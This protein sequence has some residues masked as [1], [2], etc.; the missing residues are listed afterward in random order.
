[1]PAWVV[2][3]TMMATQMEVGCN[4]QHRKGLHV[5]V[6]PWRVKPR[7]RLGW[8]AELH[9]ALPGRGSRRVHGLHAVQQW[10]VAAG[11]GLTVP[12]CCLYCQELLCCWDPGSSVDGR[13]G[14]L[15]GQGGSGMATT[16]SQSGQPGSAK[17]LPNCS[18]TLIPALG[19]ALVDSGADQDVAHHRPISQTKGSYWCAHVSWA[20]RA[21][22]ALCMSQQRIG[23]LNPVKVPDAEVQLLLP[24]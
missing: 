16:G 9:C 14:C 6:K 21:K 4:V 18:K 23:K 24:L 2:A 3:W 20:A 17:W 15:D 11:A 12:L 1:M 22:P 13:V 7:Q 10:P 5:C 8:H 19:R